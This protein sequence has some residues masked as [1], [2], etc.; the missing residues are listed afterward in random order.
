MVRSPHLTTASA[1]V[2]TASSTS[3]TIAASAQA[4][5]AASPSCNCSCN[6]SNDSLITKPLEV[7]VVEHWVAESA[8]VTNPVYIFVANIPGLFVYFAQFTIFAYSFINIT[9]L[10]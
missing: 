2:A 9:L 7:S 6:S 3:A 10:N 4:T 8:L 1:P 5:T